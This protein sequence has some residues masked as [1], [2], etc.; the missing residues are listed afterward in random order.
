MSPLWR[1]RPKI[2][3]VLERKPVA[4][5]RTANASS[6]AAS[7]FRSGG[8]VATRPEVSTN[9]TNSLQ[10]REILVKNVVC[11][12]RDIFVRRRWRRQ[13]EKKKKNAMEVDEEERSGGRGQE[14][15]D[16]GLGKLSLESGPGIVAMWWQ[17]WD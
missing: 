2:G 12:W 3:A 9:G 15:R 8:D 10:K 4:A 6:S 11:K 7:N 5:H 13:I 14:E 17:P 16:R 1:R